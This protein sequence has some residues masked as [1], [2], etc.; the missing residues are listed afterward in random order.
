M[1]NSKRLAA[2][3][4]GFGLSQQQTGRL[5]GVS[6]TQVWEWLKDPEFQ[7]LVRDMTDVH[8]GAVIEALLMG[9]MKAAARLMTLVESDDEDVALKAALALLDRAGTRGRPV[10]RAEMRQLVIQ[11]DPNEL[12]NKALMDPGVRSRIA[13][14]LKPTEPVNVEI[15]SLPSGDTLHG[16][17]IE[18]GEVEARSM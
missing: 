11:G 17:S 8:D 1:N 10:D 18:R 2:K 14:L 12:L 7:D 6:Q 16:D 13:H 5:I 9:E 4:L 15:V 3:L